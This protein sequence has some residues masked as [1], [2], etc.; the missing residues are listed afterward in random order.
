MI[1]EK[2]HIYHHF[3]NIAMNFLIILNDVIIKC[4]RFVELQ[5]NIEVNSGSNNPLRMWA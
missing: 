1:K 5:A 4:I 3:K 2:H